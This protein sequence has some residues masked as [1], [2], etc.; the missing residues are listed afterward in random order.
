MGILPRLLPRTQQERAAD[1]ERDLI[2]FESTIGRKL[3]GPIPAGHNRDFFCLDEHNW[4]WHEDWVDQNGNRVVVSTRYN[5][6]PSGVLKS[7]NGQSY[8]RIDDL[9]SKHLYHAIK[10]YVKLVKTEYYKMLQ[11]QAA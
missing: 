3:F 11:T 8:H 10:Q 9:E 4:I 5:I 2:K 7:Q 1:I 6:R